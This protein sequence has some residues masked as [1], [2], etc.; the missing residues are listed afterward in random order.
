MKA[1]TPPLLTIE[2]LT[3]AAFAPFGDVIEVD[4]AMTHYLINNDSTERYHDLARIDAGP[5]G[6][7]ILSIF[8]SQPRELPFVVAMMER[9]PKSS[10]AFYPLSSLPYLA[11]VARTTAQPTIDD[12]RVFYCEAH[13]GVN[14]SPGV[15]HHP[16]LALHAQSDFLIIDRAGPG[17]NCDITQMNICGTI[18][19]LAGGPCQT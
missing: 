2:P 19:Q 18:P 4:N 11:V 13:Q 9:H 16:L 12:L 5:E 17:E 7:A 6:H 15:W 14:Y 3:R 10:Q 8:R 1:D